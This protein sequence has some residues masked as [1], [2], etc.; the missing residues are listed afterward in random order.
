MGEG[1]R[2]VSVVD[3]ELLTQRAGRDVRDLDEEDADGIVK[4][5]FSSTPQAA[6]V[7]SGGW[8][9]EDEADDDEAID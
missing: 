5:E 7:R 9:D 6:G 3:A 1:E 8:V 4:S 2:D